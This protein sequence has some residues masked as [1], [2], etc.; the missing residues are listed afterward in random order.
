[1]GRLTTST[2]ALT[3]LAMIAFAANSILCRMALAEGAID[4]GSFTAVRIASGAIALTLIVLTRGAGAQVLA[5]GSWRGAAALVGYAIAFSF[6]YL[7]LGASTGALI[8]FGSVQ[9]TMIGVGLARGERLTPLQ[10]LGAAAAAAGLVYLLSPGLRAPPLLS[11]LLMALAGVAWGIY[12]LIGRA[13]QKFDPTLVTAGNFLRGVPLALL[14]LVFVGYYDLSPR[15]LLLAAISGAIT[16]G[17]GYV[18]WYSALKGLKA[19]EAAIVQ[20]T[21]PAIAAAGAVIFLSEPLSTRFFI[22][23]AAILGGV[24]IVLTAR[25]P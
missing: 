8:L 16:S 25:R 23:A 9:M 4:A 2:L 13:A 15:G 17:L 24:A 21:V 1:M 3:A 10:A 20:L 11:A 7:A 22:A 12:S 14:P 5:A 18:I 6:A 19:S